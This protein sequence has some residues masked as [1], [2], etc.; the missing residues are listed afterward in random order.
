[1][2]AATASATSTPDHPQAAALRLPPPAGVKEPW[3]GPAFPWDAQRAG[4][5]ND[6]GR[7]RNRARIA[8]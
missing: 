1:M 7:E 6:S 8:R 5:P 4:Q 2:A 3:G